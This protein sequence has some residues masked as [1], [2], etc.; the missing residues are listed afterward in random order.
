MKFLY[1]FVI[2]LTCSHLFQ[3][4][5]PVHEI[6]KRRKFRIRK[7]SG[8]LY[9]N[10]PRK[11]PWP[12][13]VVPYFVGKEFSRF[14]EQ[15]IELSLKHLSIQTGRNCIKF[16]RRTNEP[17]FVHIIKGNGCN[18][19]VGRIGGEQI[20][21]IGNGCL[22]MQPII[23]E[24]VHVLGF[25]HTQCRS[26]RDEYVKI[27]IKN[28]RPEFRFA[29][30]KQKTNNE[31]VP[32]DYKSIMIY[33]PNDFSSNGEPT[34][35]TRNPKNRLLQDNERPCLSRLDVEMIRRLYHC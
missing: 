1:L 27:L 30:K 35:E 26:D 25:D 29:F 13:G 11:L 28:I 19:A 15:L 18:S 9:Q 31:I 21:S 8:R 3:L 22:Q 24:A 7:R 32:F 23:H 2:I 12:S 17:D 14:E 34:M 33:S 4:V 6:R 20:M 5:Q 10:V 16:I